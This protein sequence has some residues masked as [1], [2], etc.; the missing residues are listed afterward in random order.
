MGNL[1]EIHTV[2]EKD[3]ADA[4][5][6]FAD[7]KFDPDVYSFIPNSPEHLLQVFSPQNV[8]QPADVSMFLCATIS[9]LLSHQ[10][11]SAPLPPLSHAIYYAKKK[12]K[13]EITEEIDKLRK[14][15]GSNEQTQDD[16]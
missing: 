16:E 4:Q 8:L 2:Y 10:S 13:K 9:R 6:M 3:I 15:R 11:D 12:R 7:A 1:R 14:N 5:Q